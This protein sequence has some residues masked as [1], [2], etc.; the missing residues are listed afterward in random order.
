MILFLVFAAVS[1]ILV[2]AACVFYEIPEE[3][4][5]HL[6]L[7]M[8]VGFYLFCV[9]MILFACSA[10]FFCLLLKNLAKDRI[11]LQTLSLSQNTTDKNNT[12]NQTLSDKL[13]ELQKLK[14]QN[15]LT[16]E[17]YSEKKEELLKQFK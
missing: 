2:I 9:G 14:E 16:E 7:K 10:S 5:Q 4:W 3:K 8:E 1:L 11:S 15:I 12:P 17:E 13:T 6:E